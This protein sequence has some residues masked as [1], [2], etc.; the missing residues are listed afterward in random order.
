MYS[1]V[2]SQ[3]LPGTS[4]NQSVRVVLKLR[5][6]SEE[7][8]GNENVL[9][10]RH[11]EGWKFSEYTVYPHTHTHTPI[12]VRAAAREHSIPRTLVKATDKSSF[13]SDFK[14]TIPTDRSALPR[15]SRHFSCAPI[16]TSENRPPFWCD[17]VTWRHK[18]K[19]KQLSRAF[20]ERP[21][22][23]YLKN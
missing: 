16:R 4:W 7:V 23:N 15:T 14:R 22:A 10:S 19:Y 5:M 11:A 20:S 3:N 1:E 9:G 12:R 2:F 8:L 21:I 17:D 13:P 18:S 6:F